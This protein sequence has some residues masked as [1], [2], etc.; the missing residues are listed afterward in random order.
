MK[1]EY[2]ALLLKLNQMTNILSEK[3]EK[4]ETQR[5][6]ITNLRR[7]NFDFRQKMVE[8]EDKT[9]SDKPDEINSMVSAQMAM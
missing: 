9:K 2:E 3:D 6:E 1:N 7:K 5:A 8:L 4:I